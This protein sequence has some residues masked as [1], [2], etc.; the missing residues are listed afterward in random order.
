MPPR[1]QTTSVPEKEATS[2]P[3]NHIAGFPICPETLNPS[4]F[5]WTNLSGSN[6]HRDTC[7]I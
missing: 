2:G 4:A 3:E 1:R 6:D 5:G 7:G